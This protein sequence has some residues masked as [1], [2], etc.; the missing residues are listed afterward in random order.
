MSAN[1]DSFFDEISGVD[2]YEFS[3]GSSVGQA[4]VVDW[5]Y[6]G[7]DTT[8]TIGGLTLSN[9]VTYYVNIRAVDIAGNVSDY[10]VSNGCLLYTSD[11]ADE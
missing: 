1:W 7:L 3:V 8:M 11:A 4:D 5:T 2:Y 6:N 9:T 10:I